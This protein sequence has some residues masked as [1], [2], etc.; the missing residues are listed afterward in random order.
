MHLDPFAEALRRD[1]AASAHAGSPEVR[2][3]AERLAVALDPALRLT[4]MAALAE[5]AE[6]ISAELDGASVEVRLKG[7]EPVFVVDAGPEYTEPVPA[8][9]EEDGGL[10]DSGVVRITL[11][12]PISVKTRAEELAARQGQSLNTWLVHAARLAASTADT[13]SWPPGVPPGFAP[14]ARKSGKRIQGWVR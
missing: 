2:E 3:A 13:G 8:P 9:G 11:R 1:L 7:R 14:P 4:M 5:A 10:D 12:I 6:E